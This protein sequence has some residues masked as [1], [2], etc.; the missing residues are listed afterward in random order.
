MFRH[1]HR[2]TKFK[3]FLK[4]VMKL[5]LIKKVVK[6]KLKLKNKVLNSQQ[7]FKIMKAIKTTVK[8]TIVII[9]KKEVNKVNI[10]NHKVDNKVHKMMVKYIIV[11]TKMNTI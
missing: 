7:V 1:K 9:K 6:I 11:K 5:H 2:L 8:K 10:V 4:K 3:I